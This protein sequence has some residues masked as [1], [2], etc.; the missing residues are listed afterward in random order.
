MDVLNEG[1]GVDFASTL[2]KSSLALFEVGSVVL[3]TNDGD[4]DH[5]SGHGADEDTLDLK[6][7]RIRTR[8]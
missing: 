5:E 1:I 7:G 4:N 8:Q 3:G 6:I 2:F